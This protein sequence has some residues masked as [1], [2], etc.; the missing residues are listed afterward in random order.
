MNIELI[1]ALSCASWL[2]AEGAQPIQDLKR[3]FYL[4]TAANISGTFHGFL[5]DLLNCSLCSG[6]WIALAYSGDWK[7]A[8]MVSLLSETIS[9]LNKATMTI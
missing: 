5:V 1:I 7:C 6:F 9:R 4:D 2:F 8:V 3:L